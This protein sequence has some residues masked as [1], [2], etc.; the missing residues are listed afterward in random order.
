MDYIF[1]SDLAA[2]LQAEDLRFSLPRFDTPSEVELLEHL[3]L[4]SQRYLWEREM[5]GGLLRMAG[6]NTG[7]PEMN[8]WELPGMFSCVLALE[9]SGMFG[10][11]P[12]ASDLSAGGVPGLLI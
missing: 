11:W 4:R 5:D 8:P 3:R 7:L 1:S 9:A 2:G 12:R 6:L 10:R